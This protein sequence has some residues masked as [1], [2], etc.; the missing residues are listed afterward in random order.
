MTARYVQY[1]GLQLVSSLNSSFSIVLDSGQVMKTLEGAQ[2][3]GESFMCDQGFTFVKEFCVLSEIESSL[4][5]KPNLQ[6]NL[7]QVTN[8][9]VTLEWPTLGDQIQ[10]HITG[11]MIEHRKDGNIQWLSS[12]KL[13]STVTSYNL[14]ALNSDQSFSV[15]LIALTHWS[16]QDKW[17]IGEVH[18]RTRPTSAAMTLRSNFELTE[19]TVGE[20]NAYFYWGLLP[21]Q[22]QLMTVSVLH[23]QTRQKQYQYENHAKLMDNNY[24]QLKNLEPNTAYTAEII[25]HL[26]TDEKLNSFPVHFVTLSTRTGSTE[27][28]IAVVVSSVALTSVIVSLSCVIW[29]QNRKKNKNNGFENK[30]FGIQLENN[31]GDVQTEPTSNPAVN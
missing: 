23:K 19:V 6:L 31:N 25:L 11:L 30:I 3:E 2:F 4:S 18:F 8:C 29:R 21:D 12:S 28:L 22:S 5:F 16:G 27:L 14:T 26:S 10:R 24:V 15:R 1:A 7:E 17:K 20:D 9:S 13:D